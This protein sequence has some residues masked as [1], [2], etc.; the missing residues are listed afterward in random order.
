MPGLTY[1]DNYPTDDHDKLVEMV[2]RDMM[3]L[4]GLTEWPVGVTIE[5]RIEGDDDDYTEWEVE[6]VRN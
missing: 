1:I 3:A 2:K 6:I 5:G 4:F